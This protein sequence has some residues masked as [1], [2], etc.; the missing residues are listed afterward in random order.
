MSVLDPFRFDGK[1][2]LVVGGATGMG[3]AGAELALALGAEV[4]VMDCAPITLVGV[5]PIAM[6]LTDKA[7]IEA[8]LQKLDGRV[9]AVFACAGVAQGTPGIERVN[10]TGHRLLVERLVEDG[11]L[12]RGGTVCF[13]S[14][15]AG[16]GWEANYAALNRLLDIRDFEEASAWMRDHALADYRGSK[17][18]VCAYVAREAL[19]YLKRGVRINALCPGPTDTPLARA[20]DWLANGTDFRQQAGVQPHTPMEQA[21]PM[22]FLCSPAASAITGI[23][24]VSDLS[25]FSAGFL[26]AYPPAT[27]I[28][29]AIMGRPGPFRAAA[30]K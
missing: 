29:E 14:S 10:F 2:V 30:A 24:L 6:D 15:S 27:P 11:R 1:H 18:A 17:Q 5:K 7:S 22:A 28:A 26:G 8:A 12:G 13:I 21:Y 9:D 16:L 25:W 23:T 3:A 19:N 4:T 20:H